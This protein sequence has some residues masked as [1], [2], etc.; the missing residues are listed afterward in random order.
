M[1]Y[2]I[3]QKN[4][5]G[6]SVFIILLIFMISKSQHSLDEDIIISYVIDYQTGFGPRKLIA[7][8]ISLLFGVPTMG[9]I[10]AFAFG[11]STI[12][13][14]LFSWLCNTYLNKMRKIGIDYY[15]S[16]LYLIALYLICPAALLFLLQY[17]N[18]GRLDIILYGICLLFCI[19]FFF[20]NRNRVLY[21]CGT[22][23]LLIVGILTH[24]IF[25]ATYMT[26]MVAL[27]VYDIWETYF[28]KKKFLAYLAVGIISC[29]TLASVLLF[30]SMNMPLDEATH[31]N[32][33]FELSRKFVCFGY[34]AHISD[35]IQQYFIP[36]WH[37]L[38]AGFTLTIL[39]LAPLLL[40]FWKIWQDLYNSQSKK[41]NQL[42]LIGVHSSFLLF[43]PAFCITV[44]Y[45]RW[46]GAFIFLQ[47]L[48]M[49]YFSFD[50]TCKYNNIGTII[51]K[52][53]K[54]HIFFAAF[55]LIYLSAFKYFTSDTYFD[56]V[57]LIMEKL[58]IYRV[59]TLLPPEFRV[60]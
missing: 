52:R 4:K 30:S 5:Y 33:H 16:S 59:S 1:L 19:M 46:F 42:L 53:L 21:Y 51:Y 40:A 22:M 15:L 8:V 44:D 28:D 31:Y 49:A 2:S 29:A 24:H 7:S 11:I 10:R 43:I 12:I 58:H 50:G 38:A 47:L 32:P 3:L 56:I 35:H 20:R 48:L 41:R 17:P 6:L 34:Y 55:L 54:Q 57:E 9:Q 14:V 23:V 25:V 60:D 45:L 26:F 36:K 18:V 27:F 39:F 13:C 37:R